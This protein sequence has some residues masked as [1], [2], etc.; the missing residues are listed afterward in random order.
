MILK[1]SRPTQQPKIVKMSSVQNAEPPEGAHR[2]GA[3]PARD[4]FEREAT[5]QLRPTGRPADMPR[6]H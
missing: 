5:D 4:R 1:I 6:V 3:D 2:R